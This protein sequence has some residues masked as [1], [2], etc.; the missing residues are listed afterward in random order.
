V[1][2]VLVEVMSPQHDGE[3]TVTRTGTGTAAFAARI[4]P[5]SSITQAHEA[6]TLLICCPAPPLNTV[7]PYG[8]HTPIRVLLL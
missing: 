1:R 7:A 8:E 5:T 3:A 6:S 2:I 4:C